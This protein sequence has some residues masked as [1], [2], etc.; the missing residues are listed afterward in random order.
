M[1]VTPTDLLQEDSSE[2]QT[3][4]TNPVPETNIN[5]PMEFNLSAESLAIQDNVLKTVL[6]MFQSLEAKLNSVVTSQQELRTEFHNTITVK[7]EKD[8]LIKRIAKVE[9]ENKSLT[10]RIIAL[11]DKL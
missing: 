8:K 2:S 1:N 7:E 3:E 4:P 11:E 10:D 6:N 5:T 9:S